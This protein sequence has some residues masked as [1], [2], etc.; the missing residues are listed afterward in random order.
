MNII[1]SKRRT[2]RAPACPVDRNLAYALC[3]EIF[4]T[5]INPQRVM[6]CAYNS[7]VTSYAAHRNLFLPLRFSDGE[8]FPHDFYPRLMY[9]GAI[10]V[11]G[12]KDLCSEVEG[13]DPVLGVSNAFHRDSVTMIDIDSKDFKNLETVR[14]KMRDFVGGIPKGSMNMLVAIT[15]KGYHVYVRHQNYPEVGAHLRAHH[16]AFGWDRR[17]REYFSTEG[18]STLRLSG[19]KAKG[20]PVTLFGVEQ[21]P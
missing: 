18:Q 8:H 14:E 16:R 12:I 15:R 17:H 20:G 3:K 9:E 19:S 5:L 7:N 11:R 2:V 10:L 13:V 1:G 4:P 6:I 21:H